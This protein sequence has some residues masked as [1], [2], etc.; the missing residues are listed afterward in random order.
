LCWSITGD[1]YPVYILSYP[2]KRFTMS[3]TIKKQDTEKDV[4]KPDPK[5]LN[6]TDPQENMQGPISSLVQGVKE[7]VEEGD[8]ETKKEADKKKE[9][10]M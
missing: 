8:K 6:K 1:K 10:N 3:K 4:L 2:T 5:T 7:Q 9:E